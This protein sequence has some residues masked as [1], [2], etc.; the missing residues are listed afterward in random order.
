MAVS[1]NQV[2]FE[3]EFVEAPVEYLQS[4]CPIC[5][6]ILREPY[7][8]TCCGKSFC[9]L[10]IETVKYRNK[11]CPCCKEDS[12]NDFP[13]KGLQQPLYG[14]KVY[15][16]NKEGGCEWKEELGKLDNH[17]NLSP[18][19][20]KELEG[21]EFA[22]IK[23][24]YCSYIIVRS[25]L[26][27]HKK[28]HCNKRPFS[29]LYCN[30]YRSTYEDVILNHWPMCG[31][32][33]VQCPNECGALPQRQELDD[34]I[35][36]EC[37]LTVIECEFQY[38]GCAIKL[39]R[40]NMPDHLKDSLVTHFSLLA[41]SHKQQQDKIKV[42]QKEIKTLKKRQEAQ[43]ETLIEEIREVRMQTEQLRR[44]TQL[45][46]IG[47]V[48]E[49]PH[50]Y[51]YIDWYSAPFYS[52]SQGYKL[53]LQFC[54]YTF[55]CYLMPGEFD[56]ALNWPLKG[57]LKLFL[58]YHQLQ[59]GHEFYIEL[60]HERTFKDL[61]DDDMWS[62][63]YITIDDLNPYLNNNCLHIRVIGIQL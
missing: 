32:Y 29:C 19:D 3:C 35:R 60:N 18:Q 34:H 37:P 5:L 28:E 63:G 53:C 48:M 54:R 36:E 57:V 49:N 45:V 24:S 4:E 40:R 15:C 12:F 50:A 8:V 9:R 23:C 26:L 62:C 31:Y 55:R 10:C 16:V 21:C 46:P 22:E 17:L 58:L 7:Q 42:Y 14:F 51:Y 43:V 41:M 52:H 33:P 25:K 27:H 11:P 47:F 13:N 61:D 1:K 30:E 59:D 38:A 20:D 2:G 44:H 56:D 6:H 39:P